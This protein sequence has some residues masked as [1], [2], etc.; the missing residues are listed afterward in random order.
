MEVQEQHMEAE[1]LDIS[2]EEV[3]VEDSVEFKALKI[4]FN[5]QSKSLRVLN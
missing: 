2:S 3:L 4:K 5:K 1:N